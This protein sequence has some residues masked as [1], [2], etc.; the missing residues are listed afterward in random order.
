[1]TTPLTFGLKIP[2]RFSY[3]NDLV[4]DES[5]TELAPANLGLQLSVRE[6]E[7]VKTLSTWSEYV[8]IEK[9]DIKNPNVSVFYDNK[10][11]IQ[12]VDIIAKGDYTDNGIEDLVLFTGNG[13]EGGSHF[14]SH[15]FVLSR[16]EPDSKLELVEEP[17]LLD[18]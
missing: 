7:Q 18:Y 14:S 8:K 12:Q 2:S 15:I 11:S 16:D 17:R 13:V 9:V 5:F 6:V 1:M 3:L 10:G 4:L